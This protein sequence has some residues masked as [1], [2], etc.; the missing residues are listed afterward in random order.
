MKKSFP[1]KLKSKSHLKKAK[2]KK[3]KLLERIAPDYLFNRIRV[4]CNV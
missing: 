3:E 4:I 2:S 1:S